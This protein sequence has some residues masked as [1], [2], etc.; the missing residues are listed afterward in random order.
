MRGGIPDFKSGPLY[1]G[2]R[3]ALPLTISGPQ[4]GEATYFLEHKPAQKVTLRP[5]M[6]LTIEGAGTV[7]LERGGSE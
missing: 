4:E 6:K 1:F 5:G 7:I 3:Y 2:V